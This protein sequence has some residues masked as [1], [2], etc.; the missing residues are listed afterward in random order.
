[1]KD[2]RIL[3]DD[4]LT[5][6]WQCPCGQWFPGV[7]WEECGLLVKGD[8]SPPLLSPSESTSGILF[9]VLGSSVQKRQ[10]V[11]G[12]GLA[13]ATKMVWGLEHLSCED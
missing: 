6:S 2:L 9:P 7:H 12:G 1:M 5:M 3:V 11:T 4:K 8:D 10:E 13:E